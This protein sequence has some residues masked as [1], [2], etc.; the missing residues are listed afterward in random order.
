MLVDE[1]SRSLYYY[2]DQVRITT[3]PVEKYSSSLD[4]ELPIS[5]NFAISEKSNSSGQNQYLE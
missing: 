4:L 2:K 5:E 1:K 3:A